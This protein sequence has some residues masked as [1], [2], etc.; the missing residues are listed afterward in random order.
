MRQNPHVDKLEKDTEKREE[1]EADH[2]EEEEEEPSSDLVRTSSTVQSSEGAAGDQSFERAE[3]W[4]QN[5]LVSDDAGEV[6]EDPGEE[7]EEDSEEETEGD[8]TG[9]EEDAAEMSTPENLDNISDPIILRQKIREARGENKVFLREGPP[10]L[11]DCADYEVYKGKL[12]VWQNTT[13]FSDKQQAGAVIS[14]IMDDHKNFKKG[15]QTDLMRTLTEDQK[16][17]PSMTVVMAF[18]DKHLSGTKVE[19]VHNAYVTF[20]QCEMRQGEKYEDFVMRFDTAYS[21]LQQTEK[22]IKIP[23]KILAMQLMTAAKLERA[24]LVAVRA[25]I[26]WEKDDIYETAKTAIN[27]ICHGET[28]RSSKVAQ[29]KLAT[30]DGAYEFSKEGG[31]FVVDG[32]KMIKLTE[33]QV[34]VTEATKKRTP[35]DTRGRRGRGRRGAGGRAGARGGRGRGGAEGQDH[36]TCWICGKVGH[37]QINCPDAEDDEEN[38][39]I[40]HHGWTLE[41]QGGVGEQVLLDGDEF[42]ELPELMSEDGEMTEEEDEANREYC[43]V[44]IEAKQCKTFTQEAAG[45]AAL[46]TCC[47][48]TLCGETWLDG[49]KKMMPKEMKEH[50]RGPLHSD[51]VYTFGDGKTLKSKGKYIIPV[52]IYGVKAKLVAELVD[53]DIPLLM[54]KT[55]MERCGVKLDLAERKTTV[56]GITRRMVETSL[57]HPVVG[58]LPKTPAPFQDELMMVMGVTEEEVMAVRDIKLGKKDD[59]RLSRKQQLEVIRKV[60]KQAGHQSKEKFLKFLENGSIQW[61]KAVLRDELAN[62]TNNCAGCILKKRKPDKPAACIPVADGFNQ[63]VGIDLKI[64]PDGIIL[65]VIDMWSKLIQAKFVKSKRPEDIVEALLQIWIAPFGCFDRTIHDNGGEFIGAAFEEMVDLFGIQDGT[66]GAHSPWSCGVVEKHHAVVDA[67]YEALSRDFPHYRKETLLQWAV[68][69]KNSTPGAVGWSSYQIIYGKNPKMP[70]LM[71]SNIAGLREEVLTE[72]LLQNLNALQQA[73]VEFN[74]ALGDSRLKKMIKSKVRRNNTVF[75][76]GDHVYWRTHEAHN[77]W[78]QGKCL[79]VDGKVMWVRTGSRVRRISTDMAIKTNTEFDRTGE[80]VDTDDEQQIEEIRSRQKQRRKRRTVKFDIPE[81]DEYPDVVPGGETLPTLEPDS[82]DDGEAGEDPDRPSRQI[83]GNE[84]ALSGLEGHNTQVSPQSPAER[85]ANSDL[86]GNNDTD[87]DNPAGDNNDTADEAADEETTSAEINNDVNDVMIPVEDNEARRA[88]IHTEMQEATMQRQSS[89]TGDQHRIDLKEKD[90]IIHDGQI[91]DVGK[92]LGKRGKNGRMG[93]NYNSF[94]LFPRSE[95]KPYSIDLSRSPYQKLDNNLRAGQQEQT[96]VLHGEECHMDIVPF[97]LHGNQECMEAKRQEL[98][99]IVEDYKA[100]KVVPDDGT[101]MISCK[102]VLWYKK[103]SDGSVQTR[104]RLVAR[105]F[106]E[107][108]EVASDSPTMDSTSLKIIFMTAQSKNWKVITADVKAAFLQGLPLTERTVRVK[109]PPEAMV[110]AGHVWELQVAL[111]GLQDAS[112]RFHWKVCKVFKELG[113]QQSKLD[114]AV[115][116]AKDKKTGEIRGIIGTHVDDFLVTGKKDW[117]D[118]V[119]KDI[120][121]RFELGKIEDSDFLYC[122]HRIRQ[123]GEKFVISQE[124]F[125]AEVKPFEILPVRKK[126]PSEKVT[127]KER[128]QLRSGAGKLGWMARLTRPDL[129]FAQIE[130]SSNVTR[131]E[132]SDLKQLNKAMARVTDTKCELNVPKLAEDVKKW[133]IQLFTDAAWQNLNQVGST[134]G[135]VVFISDGKFSFPVHWASHRLRRVCHS[136]QAAEIM[137]MNEGLN[138][139]AFIRQMMDEINDI[140]VPIQLTID[141]KNAYR[142]ITGTT[143]PTDKKVRCEAAGVRESLMEGEVERVRLVRGKAMLADVLTKRKVEPNDLLHIIQ[144]S[145]S[146]EKLGY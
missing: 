44:G 95:K 146:L 132:V 43:Y 23:D 103:H 83:Y 36:R 80:L 98:K 91:C 9:P 45:A 142:A 48:R 35:Q 69:V 59:K 6:E 89:K 27:R 66:S 112:L 28:N 133:K 31:C 16:K 58:I 106:E 53:S 55:A 38:F 75:E 134:G 116:Y 140:L 62:I 29:V 87:D 50:L 78:R 51:V 4:V 7:V 74:R 141:N 135:R 30:E 26:D 81:D 57:G 63:C 65:Y 129:M 131:A 1:S 82:S 119:V 17:A 88:M 39:I 143:A 77:K 64:Y 139:T 11:D 114:P 105:G 108:E 13:A 121:A 67:T 100:V 107:K 117:L 3:Q 71:T 76:V 47:S 130:A 21:A 18:L 70:C 118:K 40:G 97:K 22:D 61:D 137:S 15:L 125:A 102:F 92:R 124:E 5:I 60:H 72:E 46:D 123:E 79:A 109:P 110:P 145:D 111:Y 99:K 86:S 33:A 101:Y 12:T 10:S 34:M 41:D 37:V 14:S 25:N 20:V 8:L 136:S 52:V 104:A 85:A 144:T 68:Y 122:G 56:F 96:L 42:W 126:Q 19:T 2:S 93:K 113:M 90:V 120:G 138:D 84:G 54:S 127:E 115:F 32:E 73:R 24:T 128:A 49:Y 94:N